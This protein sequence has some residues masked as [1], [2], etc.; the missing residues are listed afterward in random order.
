[1]KA[2]RNTERKPLFYPIQVPQ[3]RELLFI[4]SIKLGTE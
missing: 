3:K 4:H 1:M 2:R